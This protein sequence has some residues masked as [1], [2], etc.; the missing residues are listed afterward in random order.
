MVKA[1]RTTRKAKRASVVA[2]GQG[3]AQLEAA[4]LEKRNLQRRLQV[5]RDIVRL[6]GQLER[7][8]RTTDRRLLDL[9][10]VLVERAA[11]TLQGDAARD[12]DVDAARAQRDDIGQL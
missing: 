3:A 6:A 8:I 9:G 10:G 4:Q 5:E 12:A 2:K 11:R 1:L 7:R